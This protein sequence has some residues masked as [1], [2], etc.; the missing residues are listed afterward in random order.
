M[1]MKLTQMAT[2]GVHNTR[3]GNELHID[4]GRLDLVEVYHASFVLLPYHPSYNPFHHRDYMH[5]LDL[6]EGKILKVNRV[7][8]LSFNWTTTFNNNNTK[9]SLQP[10]N[11]PQHFGTRFKMLFIQIHFIQKLN[12]PS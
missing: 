2:D 6:R 12:P 3:L 4:Y 11:V 5:H 7:T 1:V 9:K 10:L 8:T